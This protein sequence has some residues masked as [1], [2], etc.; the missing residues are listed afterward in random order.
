VVCLTLSVSCNKPKEGSPEAIA[1][2]FVDAYFRRADQ[3]AAKEF[4]ALGASRMLDKEIEDVAKVRADGYSPGDASLNVTAERGPRSARG[5]RVRF[6]YI[7][8]FKDPKGD[9]TKH[10]DIELSEL[11]GVWKVVRI[12]LSDDPPPAAS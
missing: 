11:D 7:V 8:K 6:D 2:A 3:A 12:G 5:N 10:A 9:V 1:D 4:T